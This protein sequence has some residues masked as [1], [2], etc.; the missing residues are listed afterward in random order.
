[1][2]SNPTMGIMEIAVIVGMTVVATLLAILG[3][4]KVIRV[5]NGLG[6]GSMTPEEK[7]VL[8]TVPLQ[9]R[10]PLLR[11]LRTLEASRGLQDH[12]AT[13]VTCL[14]QVS[15]YMKKEYGHLSEINPL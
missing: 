5:L 7:R 10:R 2:G 14:K 4:P 9:W 15:K 6:V 13:N 11:Y 8:Q 3:I 1:M 12:M